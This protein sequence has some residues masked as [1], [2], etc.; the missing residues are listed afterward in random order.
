MKMLNFCGN[1]FVL[2]IKDLRKWFCKLQWILILSESF[3]GP[4]YRILKKVKF[5]AKST[6]KTED[7]EPAIASVNNHL[8]H[9]L[10]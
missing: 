2:L 6:T 10:S 8:Q 3:K 4:K 9:G 5:T 7:G 1:V